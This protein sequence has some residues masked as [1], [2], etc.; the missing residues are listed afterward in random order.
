MCFCVGMYEGAYGGPRSTSVLVFNPHFFFFFLRWVLSL[1]LEPTG[2]TRLARQQT[3]GIS[4]CPQLKHWGYRCV[5]P[6]HVLYKAAKNTFRYPC[7]P[8]KR[9]PIQTL[10]LLFDELCQRGRQCAGDNDGDIYSA[11]FI[12]DHDLKEKARIYVIRG[13]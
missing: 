12:N 5:Q 7:F 3:P 10:P 9:F 6:C 1:S 4:V 8:R 11:S 13:K 2:T